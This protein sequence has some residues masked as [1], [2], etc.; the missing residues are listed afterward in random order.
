MSRIVTSYIIEL[1]NKSK[2]RVKLWIAESIILIQYCTSDHM[3]WYEVGV[4]AKTFV[5]TMHTNC[6]ALPLLK[7]G[8]HY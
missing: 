7:S 5:C 4:A 6:I 3:D 2:K 1:T 8:I